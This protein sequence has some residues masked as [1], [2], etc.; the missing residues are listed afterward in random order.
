MYKFTVFLKSGE[1]VSVVADSRNHDDGRL[2]FTLL[3][4]FTIAVFA[5]GAWSHLT[6]EKMAK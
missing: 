6:C 5:D 1:A 3:P 2:T 4:N